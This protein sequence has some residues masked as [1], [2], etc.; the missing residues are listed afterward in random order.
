MMF[1]LQVVVCALSLSFYLHVR[2]QLW[3][4]YEE[5]GLAVPGT[6]RIAL[7]SWLLPCS[8]ALGVV[9]GVAAALSRR[10]RGRRLRWLGIG[11]TVS[12]LTFVAAALSA[13]APLFGS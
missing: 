5:A 4:S 8:V 12:G 10:Q 13:F 11:L 7:S 6:A 3:A 1:V 9:T 2:P